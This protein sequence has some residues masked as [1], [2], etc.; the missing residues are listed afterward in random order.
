[1]PKLSSTLI[2]RTRKKRRKKNKKKNEYVVLTYQK[3]DDDDAYLL[4]ESVLPIQV[5]V[6][7]CRYVCTGRVYCMYYRYCHIADTPSAAF[8]ER[9]SDQK[10][11]Q[12]Y[13]PHRTRD[14]RIMPFPDR[15]DIDDT[16]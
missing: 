7:T 1:M 6:Y 5:Q 10:E 8:L 12:I 4:S 16:D 13:K 2:S 3:N 14:A 11:K 15:N 9:G